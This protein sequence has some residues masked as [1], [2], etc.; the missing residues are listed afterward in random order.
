MRSV[1]NRKGA[2]AATSGD[3]TDRA[4]CVVD[5]EAPGVRMAER[6]EV[7][8]LGSSNNRDGPQNR[9]ILSV[10]AEFTRLQSYTVVDNL[11]SFSDMGLKVIEF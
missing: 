2:K 7:G 8:R 5:G 6:S 3:A 1:S 11:F 4:D 9:I 10:I